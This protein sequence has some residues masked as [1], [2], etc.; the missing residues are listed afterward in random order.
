MLAI[1][2]N[3]ISSIESPGPPP[4]AGNGLVTAIDC[5]T[6]LTKLEFKFPLFWVKI[7]L[8]F[9]FIVLASTL[10]LVPPPTK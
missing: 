4:T 1:E 2:F 7:I 10:A 3:L 5:L 8:F 9:L 6:V